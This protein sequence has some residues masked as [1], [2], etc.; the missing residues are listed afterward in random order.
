LPARQR[1]DSVGVISTVGSIAA[2]YDE[3]R[4]GAARF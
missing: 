3:V 4:A 2:V 1:V